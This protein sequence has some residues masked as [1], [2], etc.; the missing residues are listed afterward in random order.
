[1]FGDLVRPTHKTAT[2]DEQFD[3]GCGGINVAR[4]MPAFAA[5]VLSVIAA[6]GVTGALIRTADRSLPC[7]NLGALSWPLPHHFH[8]IRSV[9]SER[10]YR[11][12]PLGPFAEP[13]D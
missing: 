7:G 6:V 11:V 5:D 10:I 1:L 3:P 13:H 9:A 12:V 8:R 2:Y 4:V